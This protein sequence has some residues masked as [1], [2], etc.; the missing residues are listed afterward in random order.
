M[1]IKDKELPIASMESQVAEP[2]LITHADKLTEVKRN[3]PSQCMGAPTG[4]SR[5]R[6]S[7]VAEPTLIT[8][9]GPQ[10]PDQEPPKKALATR[11]SNII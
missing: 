8:D 1:P 9:K 6:R 5:K 7:P 3:V 11:R 4:S 10:I 2:M